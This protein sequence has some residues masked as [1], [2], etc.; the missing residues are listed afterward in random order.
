MSDTNEI[1]AGLPGL[2]HQQQENRKDLPPQLSHYCDLYALQSILTHNQLWGSNIRF[3]NDKQEMDYGINVAKNV[4][5]EI[6]LRGYRGTTG[7]SKRRWQIP[8]IPDVYAV[9][10]CREPDLLS[11]W[12]GYGSH[13]QNVSIQFDALNVAVLGYMRSFFLKKVVYGE[14]DAIEKLRSELDA[15]PNFAQQIMQTKTIDTTSEQRNV[16][17]RLSPQFKNEHFREE[18]EWR[19]ISADAHHEVCHRPRDNVLLPYVKIGFP[20]DG[21]LPITGITVGPGKDSD[22]TKKSIEH[23]L[24]TNPN[25][26]DVRVEVSKIPFRV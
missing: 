8:N 10:F 16:I 17:L 2:L 18:Q 25:Y 9:C 11:Q 12:R 4:M 24:K 26:R 21:P 19:L 6:L 14:N 7:P 1:L 5:E 15:V 20:N 13:S 23:F 22:L 3:L